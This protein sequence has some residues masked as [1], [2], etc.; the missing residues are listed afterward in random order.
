MRQVCIGVHIYEQPEQL[1][2][3]LDSLRRYTDPGIQLVL[4]PDGPDPGV[5]AALRL[6]GD[7]PQLGTDDARGAAASF[8]RLAAH[9]DARIVVFLE[10]GVR[11]APGWLDRLLAALDAHPAHGIAGPSTNRSWNEQGIFRS[12][13]GGASEM[14]A[15]A[16][17]AT[18]RFGSQ[19]RSLAPLHSVADFCYAVRREVIEAIGAADEVYGL[20]PCWEMDY[21]IRAARAGW[22]G[23]WACAAYVWRA[24]PTPRRLAEEAVRFE[25]SKRRYQDKFCALR[26]ADQRAD[27]E[28][29]CRGD[30]CEH[31]APPGQIQIAI[32]L[33][34]SADIAG[35][36]TQPAQAAS[37]AD[38][39]DLHRQVTV[40]EP[41]EAPSVA[42]HGAQAA[43]LIS[44]IM[45]TRDRRA[46]IA[47][48]LVYW[49][50]QTY[51]NLELI[52]LDDGADRVADLM[53][54]DPRVR[55]V[56]LSGPQSIGAKRNLGCELA[57][58]QIIAHWD[59]D[60]WYAPHR[61]QHQAAPLLDSSADITGLETACFFDLPGWRAWRVTPELHRR[62]FV[63]DVHGGTL[64]FWRRVWERSARYPAVSIA[65][66]ALFLRVA[67]LR[68]ARLRQLPAEGSFVYLRHGSNAWR[69]A[70]GTHVDPRGWLPEEPEQFI[71]PADLPF[72]RA[73]SPALSRDK[74]PAEPSGQPASERETEGPLVSCIM[75]TFNRRRYV[76]QA[77]RYF[78]RQ[79]YARRE[80]IILD[81][82]DD[83]VEDLVPRD[84]GIRYVRLP[85]RMVLGAKRNLACEMARGEIIAHWDD[86]D[87]MA[88][89]RLTYELAVLAQTGAD[90]CGAPRQWYYD[91][92]GDR[93]WLYEYP[94]ARR[95]WL[96][97]NT[98]CYR[99]A[100]WTRNRFPEIQVGEDTR[101]VWSPR[102]RNAV[103]T[104]DSDF[105]VA[106]V[107]AANTSPKSLAGPY[108]RPHPVGEVHR[109][110]GGDL[111]FYR[112][113]A[114]GP[115]VQGSR[116][117]PEVDKWPQ[118]L[119]PDR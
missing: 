99:K 3:T 101:F 86:D 21:N 47:Q 112:G 71:P 54:A 5:K 69:F 94:A 96:A 44:C 38:D 78:L 56:G 83:P 62:L 10:S 107:H 23:V 100:F 61:L 93:A 8:N 106:L 110:L 32:S 39:R 30:A 109:L 22:Q 17:A 29:H 20:G 53:P 87:W 68:G 34:A 60:D 88:P 33:A 104:P 28:P 24:P 102:A 75:P 108:W 70:A 111:N 1:A 82:G 74:T 25:A 19:V 14:A 41:V 64:V 12:A 103:P 79:D 77:I 6:L 36:P 48:A 43:P 7:L 97:G 9:D 80:L 13:R 115:A 40:A 2:A 50:R 15:T 89:H 63:H 91:P 92:L 119:D 81:D 98:L 72:Y 57:H 66:D 35:L 58:G 117:L 18:L 27:Y 76:A 67:C 114:V 11:V 118:P 85:R 84:V 42:A 46:F 52:V 95:P 26:L 45:P 4:L 31:F 105:Y 73:L 65:E 59:D 55:Y 116:P 113:L 16:R 90:L 49:A 37:P 51:P